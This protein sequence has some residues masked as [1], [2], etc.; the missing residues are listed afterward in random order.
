MNR[1]AVIATL[2]LSLSLVVACKD[3]NGPDTTNPGDPT[4]ATN[5]TGDPAT[6][7]TD[8]PAPTEEAGPGDEN[9]P[10]KKVCPAET[11]DYPAPYF[12]DTVLLRLPKNVTEDNFVE[13]TPTFA[14]LST[15]VESVGC[16]PDTPGA[17]ISYMAMT[18]YEDDTAKDLATLRDETLEVMGYK[19]ATFTD[20]KSDAAGRVYQAVL[21]VPPDDAK[22]EP[23]RALFKMA[24]AN[25]IMYAIVME[26]HPNAWNALK[27]T[28]A[29][30]ADGMRF[31]PAQ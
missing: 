31:L 15:E 12:G 13:F 3:N 25:G 18:F 22:P 2:S 30:T 21:D 6:E 1:F 28:F 5:T 10:T 24:A 20:E 26:T 8:A 14:R 17:M 27:E 16:V 4:A 11:A 9:D 7:S 23:A 29:A 19:G